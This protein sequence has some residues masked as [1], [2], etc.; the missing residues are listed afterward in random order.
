MTL[1]TL[2]NQLDKDL[3]YF[4]IVFTDPKSGKQL[5]VCCQNA[6]LMSENASSCIGNLNLEVEYFCDN[7][8]YSDKN[9]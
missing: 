5:R 6:K 7:L 9:P 4:K 1:K 3:S 8:M 2:S